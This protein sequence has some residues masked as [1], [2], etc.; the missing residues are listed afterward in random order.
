LTPLIPF[1]QLMN[2]E[3]AGH[4][5]DQQHVRDIGA[6]HAAT[7]TLASKKRLKHVMA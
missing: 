7:K 3:R 2:R 6:E 1:E 4:R 5:F